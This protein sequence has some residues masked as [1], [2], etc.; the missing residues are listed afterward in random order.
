[1]KKLFSTFLLHY[2]RLLAKVQ[3]LKIHPTIIGVTGSAGKTST[4]EACAA[5]LASSYKIK[6]SRKANSESGIPL[7]ILGLTPHS[8]SMTEWLR[9]AVLA[10]LQ[11]LFNWETYDIYLV[12]MGIDSPFPPKNMGYLLSILKPNVGIFMNVAPVH[13]ET[14]DPLIK[15]KDPQKRRIELK[16]AIAIEKGK[17]ILALPS[18]GTAI[19]NADEP[20]IAIFSQFTKAPSLTFGSS[21]SSSVQIIEMEYSATATIIHYVIQGQPH[22][23]TMENMLLP[24]HYAHTFGAAICCGLSQ[25]I[26]PAVILEA[27]QTGVHLPPGRAT[28]LEGINDSTILDSTYNAST[29]PMLDMLTLLSK[30]PGKRKLALLGDMRELGNVSQQ[31]HERVAQKA[32]EVCDKVFLVGPQMQSYVQPVLEKMDVPVQWC[33]NAYEAARLLQTVLKKGDVLLVKGSQ[34]TL[35]LEIAVEKLMAHPETADD[36]L[37][38]RGA[39]WDKEREKLK[40]RA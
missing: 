19:L 33:S 14:F 38:R 5:V 13:S 17:M 1:M 4:L 20:E 6:V 16:H 35:L 3:L 28:L 37:C 10:P 9:L 36:L 23:I 12:E 26:S 29:R 24:E 2:F 7:N 8:Y 18:N 21:A 22:S 15:T 31:E 32:G 25:N 34:N 40:V 39:Y 27:L 30:V 11:L